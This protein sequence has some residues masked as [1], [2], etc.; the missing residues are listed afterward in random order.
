MQVAE[1][2]FNGLALFDSV[3]VR[4]YIQG[5]VIGIIQINNVSR[6]IPTTVEED[7]AT[8]IRSGTILLKR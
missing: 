5:S 8:R 2:A 7:S 1:E 3:T 6:E 4:V